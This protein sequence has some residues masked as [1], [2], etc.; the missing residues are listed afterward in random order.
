M[1]DP[2]SPAIR[3]IRRQIPIRHRKDPSNPD[4]NN[5]SSGNNPGG[6]SFDDI[7]QKLKDVPLWQ[8]IAGVISIIL[9]IIFLSKTAKY[10]NERKKFKKK[11]DKLDTSMYAAGFL[12]V[13]MSIWTA[14]ACVLIGLAVVS[15]VM[16]LIAKNRCNKAEENYEEQLE[17]YNEE[18]EKQ[19]ERRRIFSSTR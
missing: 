3:H 9:T 6:S 1:Y 13:A 8:I 17:E 4:D 5:P 10:D 18:N 19:E 11:A 2:N 14:I 15:F 16:M 12:G 7:L